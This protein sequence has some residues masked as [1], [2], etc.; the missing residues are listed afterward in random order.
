MPHF[1]S[2]TQSKDWRTFYTR[3]LDYLDTLDIEPDQADDN[4]KGWKQLKLM[5][6]GKD[7]QALQTLIDNQTIMPKDMKKPRGTLDA[8]T[9]T[10]KSKENFW[11]YR[12]GLILDVR[13]QPSNRI[14]ALSQCISNLITQCRFTHPKTQEMLKIMVFQYAVWYH[15]AGDWIRQQ[16]QFQITYQSLLSHCK[17]LESRCEQYQKAR[18]R[19]HAN[20]A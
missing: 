14:H 7:R 4:L 6:E 13:Q 9:A 2:P 12:D 3:A 15:E 11:A 19:G 17:L 8:I 5:Y 10:I 1:N 16:Y 20:L 18:E